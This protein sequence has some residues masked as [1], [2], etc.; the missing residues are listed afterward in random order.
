MPSVERMKYLVTA[1]PLTRPQKVGLCL[2]LLLILVFGVWVEFRGAFLH[3]RMTDAGVYLRAAWA[4]RNGKDIYSITDDRGWHYVY[5]PLLA[6]AMTPL[7]DPPAGASR[8]GYLP[9]AVSIGLWYGLTL[10]MGL[11]GVHILA[12][13]LEDTSGDPAIR[14]QPVF[15]RRW[16]ALRILPVLIL[17]P[18]IGR[19]QMRGQVD[20]LLVLLLCLAGASILRGRRLLAGFWLAAAT[21]IKIIPAFLLL[22]PFWRRDLRMLSGSLIGLILG[23]VVIPVIVMGPDRAMNGY[24]DLYRQTV[25]AS[26]TGDTRGPLSDELTG[27]TS[28]DSNSPMVI[29]HNIIHPVKRNRPKVAAEG[30]RLAHWLIAFVL[31]LITLYASGWKRL[32]RLLRGRVDA[33]PRELLLLGALLIVMYI[34][35]PVFSPHYVSTALPLVITLLFMIWQ[36]YPYP[37]I[38]AVWKILFLA[39]FAS[40]LLTSIDRGVFL[41]LRDFGLVLFT[42]L[43]LWAGSIVMLRRTASGVD[44]SSSAKR[45]CAPSV[46]PPIRSLAVVSPVFNERRTVEAMVHSA[47]AFVAANPRYRFL[48]VDDG[49]D[50]GAGE[51]LKNAVRSR[52]QTNIAFLRYETNEGKGYAVRTGF[53]NVDADAL[54]F[55]D[56]DM[57][58]PLEQL[59]LIEDAL[60]RSDVVIGSRS[61]NSTRGKSSLRRKLMGEGF[62]RLV[63][64]ILH[65]PFRDTQAGLKGFRREAARAI[66]PKTS[67]R[68]FGF[69]V[70][71]LFIAKKA[72][73]HITEIVA[74]E[75]KQHSYKKGKLKLI[76]DSV[77]M[78]CNLLLIRWKN[79]SGH[80]D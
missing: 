68:G 17:L 32:G 1:E 11:L 57:A 42:S 28:T 13:A 73:F 53:D 54:C 63:R 26:I 25:V 7:A 21:C 3:L 71:L 56:S 52:T 43:A 72:G 27:I 33:E 22:L 78:F 36:R 64:L 39:L 40:H 65:L 69:D 23:L 20:M 18:A 35:S 46:L 59:K 4:V 45:V 24:S 61:V 49:S 66:L 67:I 14:G 9:Y 60:Q 41:Y 80:Y 58:Y 6:I 77:I 55:I 38:P 2:L 76:K 31:I 37:H 50:D 19:G 16:W 30:V 79:F 34:M 48:F 12:K 47:A 44:L 74:A 75:S 29:L 5:P 8:E 51:I 15:C 70:E 62:N 10:I